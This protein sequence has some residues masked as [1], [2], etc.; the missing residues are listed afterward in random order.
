MNMKI[1]IGLLRVVFF[2][3][4]KN[5][6]L[7][8][9]AEQR[10]LK[11]LQFQREVTIVEDQEVSFYIYTKF[12]SKNRQGGFTNLHVEN[13]VVPLYQNLSESGSCHVQ[14]L[15]AYFAKLPL[16]AKE[17]DVFYL[18]PSKLTDQSKPW[19]LLVPVNRNRLGSMLKDMC[20][21]AQVSGNFTNHS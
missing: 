1:P 3:N 21:E 15:D 2:Y 4:G 7:R 16:Q 9:S 5:F 20:T 14:I 13:K 12:G 18:T 6:C 11:L 10:N 19:Y 17:K 8:G